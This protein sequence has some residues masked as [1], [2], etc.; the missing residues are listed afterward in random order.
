MLEVQFF[1]D[2]LGGAASHM[3][4]TGVWSRVDE[5]QYWKPLCFSQLLSPPSRFIESD[6]S[7]FMRT[8][9]F[10]FQT[11][12]SLIRDFE[13]FNFGLSLEDRLI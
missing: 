6:F 8:N 11:S 12:T 9:R 5:L 1:M 10:S 13:L 4:W 3:R 2:L 7:L